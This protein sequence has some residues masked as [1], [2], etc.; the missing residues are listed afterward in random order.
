MT[1]LVV[2]S[3]KNGKDWQD[4]GQYFPPGAKHWEQGIVDSR[5]Q[6]GTNTWPHSDE[7]LARNESG[8]LIFL[9]MIKIIQEEE[10][11]LAAKAGVCFSQNT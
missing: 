6:K 11:L 3:R 10:A 7:T 4:K 1:F 5:T 8:S 9:K 2:P